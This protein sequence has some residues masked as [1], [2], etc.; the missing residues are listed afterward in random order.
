[1]ILLQYFLCSDGIHK[2]VD[3]GRLADMLCR[4]GPLIDKCRAVLNYAIENGSED[5]LSIVA[6]EIV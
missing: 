1:M 4:G 5:D 6:V 3:G 2:F